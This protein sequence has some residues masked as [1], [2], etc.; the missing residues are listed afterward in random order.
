MTDNYPAAHTPERESKRI[1]TEPPLAATTRHTVCGRLG[2]AMV[3][4]VQE[5]K[6]GER[7]PAIGEDSHDHPHIALDAAV[8]F[9]YFSCEEQHETVF[10]AVGNCS[11]RRSDSSR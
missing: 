5:T 9:P 10:W 7:L 6:N 3:V 4:V 1:H 2:R 8:A 11:I